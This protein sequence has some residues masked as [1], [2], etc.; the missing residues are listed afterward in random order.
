MLDAASLTDLLVESGALR[1][2]HFLLSSGRHSDSYVQCAL[3]LEDPWRAAAVGEALAERLRRFSP[4]AVAAPALGGMIVG[5]EVARAL[6]VPFRFTERREGAMTLRRGFRLQPGGPVVV[7]EDVVTTGGSVRETLAT[8]RAAGA[9][10]VAVGAILDRSKGHT[11][12]YG[13]PFESL[14]ARDVPSWLAE[15]CPLCSAGRPL[16]QQGSR[17]R[18]NSP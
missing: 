11:D 8:L 9:V 10:V 5:H 2:G 3:L 15:E 6:G 16:D 12:F 4:V 14:L 7:V 18:R 1:S 17:E 13:L